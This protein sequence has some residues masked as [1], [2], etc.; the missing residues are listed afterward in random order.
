[1]TEKDLINKIY[2][3]ET[4]SDFYFVEITEV[5]MHPKYKDEAS[6][7][8]K[9][10]RVEVI[11]NKNT[12]KH[13]ECI[14]FKINRDSYEDINAS[15]KLKAH[16]GQY[17]N[18][19]HFINVTGSVVDHGKEE[20][21]IGSLIELNTDEVWVVLDRSLNYWSYLASE[22]TVKEI[23][24]D[25]GYDGGINIPEE[26]LKINSILLAEINSGYASCPWIYLRV[27]DIE[28]NIY[29]LDILK[30]HYKRN[31]SNWRGYHEYEVSPTNETEDTIT[32]NYDGGKLYLDT[33]KNKKVINLGIW[34]EKPRTFSYDTSD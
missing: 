28:G 24:E 32:A 4:R 9:P 17:V 20:Y 16:E 19:D 21:I 22:N 13:G 1:M 23:E 29:N 10:L 27:S 25:K 15:F 6:V 34:D 7:K 2:F 18:G 33:I 3:A 8:V 11:E 14:K 31:N 26:E 12:L 30:N 5:N